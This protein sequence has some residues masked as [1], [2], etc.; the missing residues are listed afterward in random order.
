MGGDTRKAHYKR[1]GECAS[2]RGGG[3][4][5][6][7]PACDT[8]SLAAR[9]KR[10]RAGA[11]PGGLLACE[12]I[13]G[14]R[15]TLKGVAS[16][17]RPAAA[18]CRPPDIVRIRTPREARERPRP[19]LCGACGALRASCVV[20]PVECRLLAWRVPSR[21]V[22]RSSK[23]CNGTGSVVL[24]GI[25][26]TVPLHSSTANAV[27]SSLFTVRYGALLRGT[28]YGPHTTVYTADQRKAVPTGYGCFGAHRQ[29]AR[30]ARTRLPSTPRWHS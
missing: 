23:T 25:P 21:V 10:L 11:G 26:T 13:A 29:C 3:D 12:G 30:C 27:F 19:L 7:G 16:A 18:T 24:Y 1:D 5:V 28:D 20:G 4:G 8:P 2:A 6:R 9:A 22:P 14:G 15:H 17:W